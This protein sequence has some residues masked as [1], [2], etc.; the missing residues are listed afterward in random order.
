MNTNVAV[1]AR[2]ERFNVDAFEAFAENHPAA[3]I[4]RFSGQL[5]TSTWGVD[6]LIQDFLK[7]GNKRL[8]WAKHPDGGLI[9]PGWL[10]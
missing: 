7:A 1:V 2:N 8:P 5:I 10:F 4:D 9:Q 3:F 6:D